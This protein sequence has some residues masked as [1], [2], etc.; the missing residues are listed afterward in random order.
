MDIEEEEPPKSKWD[1]RRNLAGFWLLGLCDYFPYVVM[2]SAAKEILRDS[3]N[4]DN[5]QPANVTGLNDTEEMQLRC[6]SVGTGAVLL[7]DIIPVLFIKTTGAFFLKKVPYYCRVLAV[8][9][10]GAASFLT[11]ALSS[12]VW[13]SLLGV[14]FASISEGLGEVTFFQM[15]VYFDQNVVSAFSS[16]TG[17]AG[18]LGAL[19]Y[20]GLRTAGVSARNCLFF[21]LVYPAIMA[22]TYFLLLVKPPELSGP[23]SKLNRYDK[24]IQS[25][26]ENNSDRSSTVESISNYSLKEKITLVK[27]LLKY[28]V[29]LGL[30]YFLEYFI[31]QGLYEVLYFNDIW[32]TT[33]EQYEWYQMDYQ[34]GVFLSRSSVNLIHINKIWVFPILQGI[35]L[36]VLAA[37]AVYRFIPS[38]W[39]I[40]T[41]M[42]WEGLLGGATFVNTFYRI[43]TE[44]REEHREFSMGVVTL[45]DAVGIFIA[46]AAALPLHTY[47]CN[48]YT[49]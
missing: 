22:A 5:L 10:F 40:L 4:P 36:G 17:A 42:F 33:D 45:A 44:V 7:A 26:D 23:C 35:N 25:S 14:V 16:G 31:N 49:G 37:N 27:P 34:L 12:T 48:M 9:A 30:V 15:T 19:T 21:M 13:V 1:L 24:L 41:L 18:F 6:N 38:I 46:G 8:V 39:I 3:D 11:V 43:R 28:M 29:P 2:L 32:L 20:A 47:L